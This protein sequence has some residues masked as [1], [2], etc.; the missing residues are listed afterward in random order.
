MDEMCIDA[1][2]GLPVRVPFEL[3]A[4]ESATGCCGR[5]VSTAVKWVT[6]GAGFRHASLRRGF[7]PHQHHTAAPPSTDWRNG[8][9]S[10]IGGLKVTCSNHVS[11]IPRRRVFRSRAR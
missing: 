4:E 8:S 11:V 10:Q 9:A 6:R 7:E 3:T 2:W 5:V 1:S